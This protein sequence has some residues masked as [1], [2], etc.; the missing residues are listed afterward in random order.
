[1]LRSSSPNDPGEDTR[2]PRPPPPNA[3]GK[4]TSPP[5]DPGTDSSSLDDRGETGIR[6][7]H[8]CAGAASIV[9]R[10]T[11]LRNTQYVQAWYASTSGIAI[12]AVQLMI[13][14]V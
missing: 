11:R 1:M 4:D 3:P 13:C 2:P 7:D 5:N 12:S 10:R 14:R 6:P 8:V 9:E